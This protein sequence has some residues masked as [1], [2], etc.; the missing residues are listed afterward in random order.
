M[1]RASLTTV[2]LNAGEM[3]LSHH[4][5]T[6]DITGSNL[7]FTLPGGM[8]GV[9]LSADD[10]LSQVGVV[11]PGYK[12]DLMYTMQVEGTEGSGA[13]WTFGSLQNV[14]IVSLVTNGVQQSGDAAKA[15]TAAPR[16]YILALTPQDA[17]LLKYLKDA[18]AI[19]DLA[20]RNVA[21]EGEH[22]TQPV[23]SQYLI[24][25]FQLRPR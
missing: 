12:V 13:Q 10:L 19:M 24:D 1:P 23:D 21:D 9:T 25:K 6:P 16:A 4:L 22:T 11:Q 5:V 14:T 18:G 17:L 7:S 15:S 3:V 20:L 8:V 2:A